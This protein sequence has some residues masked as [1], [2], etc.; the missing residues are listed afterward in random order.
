VHER[1]TTSPGPLSL[2]FFFF[3]FA[4]SPERAPRSPLKPRCARSRARP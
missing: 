3:F 1:T 2:P 4:L